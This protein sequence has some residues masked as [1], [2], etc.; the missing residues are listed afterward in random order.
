MKNSGILLRG[1]RRQRKWRNGLRVIRGRDMTITGLESLAGDLN[2]HAQGRGSEIGRKVESIVAGWLFGDTASKLRACGEFTAWAKEASPPLAV[3]WDPKW[4][5]PSPQIGGVVMAGDEPSIWMLWHF[6]FNEP[7]RDR[8]KQ[9]PEC[10]VWF[11]D[12]TK[13]RV[14]VR[15]SRKCTNRMWSRERRRTVR[16]TLRGSTRQAKRRAKS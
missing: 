11:V 8:L 5:D 7:G 2:R 3:Y 16:Q 13:G 12:N 14:K 1:T 9:C 15:C 10:S 4:K 6:F